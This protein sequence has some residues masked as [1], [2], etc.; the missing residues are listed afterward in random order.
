MMRVYI[1]REPPTEQQVLEMLEVYGEFI[2]LA[3]DVERGIAAGGSKYHADG[4]EALLEDGSRQAD[5]WGA[6]WR[7]G[8]RTV[9][10]NAIINIRPRDGNRS[11]ELMDRS[12]RARVEAV[13]RRLFEEE[14]Q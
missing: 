3:V 6:D 2:K 1:L 9:E 13:V 10:F 14:R 4:E 11:P 7:P 5:I 8:P 12:L